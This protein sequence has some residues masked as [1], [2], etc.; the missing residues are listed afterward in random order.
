MRSACRVVDSQAD[1]LLILEEEQGFS[2]GTVSRR[3]TGARQDRSQHPP[4]EGAQGRRALRR[5]ELS[6]VNCGVGVK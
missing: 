6:S 2:N 4:P 3:S 1:R 5:G